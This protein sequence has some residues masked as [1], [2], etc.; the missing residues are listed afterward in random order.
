[1]SAVQTT[2]SFGSSA[3]PPQANAIVRKWVEECIALCT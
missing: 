1:M 3:P 2:N